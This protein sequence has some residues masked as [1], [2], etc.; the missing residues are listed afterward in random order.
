MH[1]YN[2]FRAEICKTMMKVQCT[3]LMK[4]NAN[5][6]VKPA[7]ISDSAR[8]CACAIKERKNLRIKHCDVTVMLC[9]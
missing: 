8:V 4:G 5:C 1:H 2:A 7:N 6:V 3:A 9:E